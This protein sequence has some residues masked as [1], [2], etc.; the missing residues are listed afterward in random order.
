MESFNY[1]QLQ[2]LNENLQKWITMESVALSAK[3]QLV[4][5]T[6]RE[7]DSYLDEML[8]L[9]NNCSHLMRL[10]STAYAVNFENNS[11]IG[12]SALKSGIES[13]DSLEVIFRSLK[14]VI[15]ELPLGE[16]MAAC[17]DNSIAFADLTSRFKEI[18]IDGFFASV[19]RDGF[20]QFEF[21]TVCF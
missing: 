21:L 9:I 7:G 1:A 8:S 2:F 15:N 10:S 14:E 19:S 6:S 20:Q 18:D 11:T 17:F 4:Y 13:L 3:Q 12:S 16:L 5:L